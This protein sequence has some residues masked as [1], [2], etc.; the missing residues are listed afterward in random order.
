MNILFTVRAPLESCRTGDQGSKKRG[1]SLMIVPTDTPGVRIRPIELMDGNEFTE[2]FFDDVRIPAEQRIGEENAAWR[3]IAEAL[4]DERHVHFGPGRVR[5]DFR[6]VTEF[7]AR[8]G[9]DRQPDI[10]RTLAGIAVGAV[11]ALE[12]LFAGPICGASM[13]PARSLAPAFASGEF[14][15]LWIYLLAPPLG[16]VTA[17]AGCIC[18]RENCCSACSTNCK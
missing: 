18:I 10:H 12:A 16:A 3:M 5:S 11:I 4:A 1:L 17:V 6:I 14:N 9:L 7:A 15:D 8:T 13:N 2:I